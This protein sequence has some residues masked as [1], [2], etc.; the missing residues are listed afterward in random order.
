MPTSLTDT[1]AFTDPVDAPSDSDSPLASGA[2]R[3]ALQALTNRSWWL[4][5]RMGVASGIAT[6]DAGGRL[7]QLPKPGIVDQG[8]ASAT[9][10]F[11]T[12]S[13]TGVDVTGS[14]IT[15]AAVVAG[16]IIEIEAAIR[17][18]SSSSDGQVSIATLES[19]GA[20]VAKDELNSLGAG[21][22]ARGGLATIAGAT[23][24]D[25]AMVQRYTVVATGTITIKL[26]ALSIG[27]VNCVVRSFSIKARQIRA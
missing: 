13:A 26:K 24:D 27:A 16:D 23:T 11:T 8:G 4:K 18:D 2:L 15:F 7:V 14:G 5:Q 6:L 20:A 22:E 21:H 1:D 17:A 10:A 9:G 12:A 3:T 19:G 25:H